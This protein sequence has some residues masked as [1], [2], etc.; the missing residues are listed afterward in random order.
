MMVIDTYFV[1][2]I[3]KL[4][5]MMLNLNQTL[6]CFNLQNWLIFISNLK[7]NLENSCVILLLKNYN[8]ELSRNQKDGT[9]FKRSEIWREKTGNWRIFESC[10]KVPKVNSSNLIS[11]KQYQSR[12]RGKS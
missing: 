1:W 9:A 2:G 12:H 8:Y 6:F 5:Y 11:K 10:C 7:V 4:A 3:I